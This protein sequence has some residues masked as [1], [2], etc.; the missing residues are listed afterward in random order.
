MSIFKT[1]KTPLK[2]WLYQQV[3]Q[4]NRQAELKLEKNKIKYLIDF[5][6]KQKT[7]VKSFLWLLIA[8]IILEIALPL[9]A[10]YKIANFVLMLNRQEAI[11]LTLVLIILIIL[12]LIVSFF[13]IKKEKEIVVYLINHIRHHWFAQFLTN[14]DLSTPA[15]KKAGLLAKITYHFPLLQ[16][17]ISNSVINIIKFIFYFIGVLILSALISPQL[18]IIS[19]ISL[20]FYLLI[21][22]LSYII[23]KKYVSQETT[24]YSDI[25]KHIANSIYNLSFFKYRHNRQ[26][27]NQKLD[28]L[29]ELDTFFRV[30]RE[31][32][33][34]FGTKIIFAILI[35]LA[36]LVYLAELYF[37]RFFLSFQPEQVIGLGIVLLYLSR[38][39]YLSVKIGLFLFPAKLGIFLAVPDTSYPISNKFKNISQQ[40]IIFHSPKTK[41]TKHSTYWKNIQLQFPAASNNLIIGPSQSGKSTLAL[42]LAGEQVYNPKAWIIKIGKKRIG[43]HHWQKQYQKAMLIGTY[44]PLNNNLLE[45][46]SG[47]FKT[48]VKQT[49]LEQIIKLIENNSALHCLLDLPNFVNTEINYIKHSPLHLFAVQIAHCLFKQS[50]LII[51]DNMWL[52]LNQTEINNLIQL[53]EE[54]LQDSTIIQFI[55]NE[56]N[57]KHYDQR[58][59]ITTQGPVKI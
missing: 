25:I 58:Y 34:M 31:L 18:L 56:N 20:M 9:L 26:A 21:I 8:Q 47:K 48:E 54:K 4:N 22:L 6:K 28:D 32:W 24:L 36:A 2:N 3:K 29:V 38:L 5:L 19:L 46:I 7:L 43:Y 59:Q 33:L 27:A 57:K 44:L 52:D 40:D 35:M 17:G 37:P 12:Y 13:N 42:M 15:D 16:M 45:I 30:R 50:S 39:A 23:A 49:E 14:S 11:I 51:I 10:K 55:S 1:E 53:L 41:I